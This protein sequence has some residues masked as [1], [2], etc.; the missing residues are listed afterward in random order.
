MQEACGVEQDAVD[1]GAVSPVDRRDRLAFGVG[2]EDLEGHIEHARLPA[3]HGVEFLGCRG[4]IELRLATAQILHVS[5]LNQQ[6][7]HRCPN[8]AA[9]PQ[10]TAVYARST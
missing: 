5:A 10:E 9:V 2:V 6:Q 3:H 4:S 1:P 7:L 8:T